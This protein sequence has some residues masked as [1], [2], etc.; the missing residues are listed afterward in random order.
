MDSITNKSTYDGSLRAT[1][2]GSVGIN[3][4][5]KWFLTFSVHSSNRP[6]EYKWE[7]VGILGSLLHATLNTIMSEGREPTSVVFV[8]N[9]GWITLYGGKC[10]QALNV[11]QELANKLSELSGQ[12]MNIQSV[13]VANDGAWVIHAR[14]DYRVADTCLELAKVWEADIVSSSNHKR[15]PGEG[16]VYEIRK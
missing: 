14:N 16:N 13:A 5:D 10:F 11:P 12:A 3:S 6:T 9:G 7:E 8:P 15:S 4:D 2:F 1:R